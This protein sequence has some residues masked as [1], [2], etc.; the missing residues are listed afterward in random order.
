MLYAGTQ[1]SVLIWF[2]TLG[3][4][5]LT[6][7]ACLCSVAWSMHLQSFA[8]IHFVPLPYCRCPCSLCKLSFF[9]SLAF[10]FFPPLCLEFPFQSFPSSFP[11]LHLSHHINILSLCKVSGS[12]SLIFLSLCLVFNEC[13]TF[14]FLIPFINI[15]GQ[16]TL[17]FCKE[18]RSKYFRFCRPSGLCFSYLTLVLEHKAVVDNTETNGHGC[19]PVTLH[20]DVM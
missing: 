13:A 14:L 9:G 12:V 2:C 1:N 4:P 19:V 11:Q 15:R 20:L 10:P 5:Q 3:I 17:F 18:P 16:Q 6:S 8:L 7:I